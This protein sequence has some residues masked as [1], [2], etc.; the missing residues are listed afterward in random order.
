[1]SAGVPLPGNFDVDMQRYGGNIGLGTYLFS[2]FEFE[3][4]VA[5]YDDTIEVKLTGDKEDYDSRQIYSALRIDSLDNLN[6]PNTGLSAKVK[7]IKEIDGL[8]GDYDF[9][10]IYFDIE[11]PFNFGNH[12][13][14]T[15]LKYGE[16][17]KKDGQTSL[18]EGF[19]LGGLFNLSGFA[20]YSLNDDN[21][22]L[23]VMK[24]RYRLRD[25][26]LFGT[27]SAPLYTGFSAEIGNTWDYQKNINFS[28]MH[29]SGSIYIA[30]DTPF[31]PFYLAYG[32]SDN[33]ES[34][35]Y[36]YLGEKF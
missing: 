6:F 28:K 7:W 14:T 23:G 27:L 30:A 20:P 5:A 22:F 4:G 17:Y 12:N 26:G 34:A 8:G 2:D 9:E 16:T 29:K 33:S 11:K 36:L 25:G 35:F 32:H 18:I 19:T 3:L 1:M 24:Y 21:I 15:Y 10:Q 31:G 13:I